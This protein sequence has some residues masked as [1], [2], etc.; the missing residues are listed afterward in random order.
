MAHNSAPTCWV[1]TTEHNDHDQHGEYLC[2]VWHTKPTLEQLA[3]HFKM[4]AVNASFSNPMA[5]LEF[6]LHLH[7]GGGR[8]EREHQ[9]W[10]LTAVAFGQPYGEAE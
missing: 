2:C 6:L 7:K 9:W 10:N 5:A 3:Q 8:Q 1:L 4:D